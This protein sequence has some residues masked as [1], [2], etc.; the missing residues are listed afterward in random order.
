[1]WSTSGWMEL[2]SSLTLMQ[3]TTFRFSGQVIRPV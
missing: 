1:M 2:L 3:F